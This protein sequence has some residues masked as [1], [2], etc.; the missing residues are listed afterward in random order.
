MYS[1]TFFI[2]ANYVSVVMFNN[3]DN[4]NNI[5]IWYYTYVRICVHIFVLLKKCFLKK[6]FF[7][8]IFQRPWW[9]VKLYI[10]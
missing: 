8:K 5:L 2:K 7:E 6:L 1:E 9:G 4:N 3:G 10:T